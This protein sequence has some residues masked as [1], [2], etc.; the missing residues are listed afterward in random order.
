MWTFIATAFSRKGYTLL[1]GVA[2]TTSV[3]TFLDS[4][5]AKIGIPLPWL[6]TTT[7]LLLLVISILISALRAAVDPRL[8]TLKAVEARRPDGPFSHARAIFVLQGHGLSTN[9][10]ISFFTTSGHAE[11][12]IGVGAI[13]QYQSNGA[14][15]ATLDKVHVG[16]ELLVDTLIGQSPA[17][18]AGVIIR[19]A[20]NDMQVSLMTSGGEEADARRVIDAI[21]KSLSIS[22][23]AGRTEETLKGGAGQA[24]DV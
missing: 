2:A 16:Q 8:R 11:I 15:L 6:I 19:P 14:W 24:D 17:G 13:R 20:I 22:R 4:D 7:L 9:D 3:A 1:G 12:P 23:S 18:L 10:R 21:A 5:I